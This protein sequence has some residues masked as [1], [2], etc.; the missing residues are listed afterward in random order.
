MPRKRYLSFDPETNAETFMDFFSNLAEN[1]VSVLHTPPG[2]FGIE[3]VK[4]YYEKYNLDVNDFTLS[5]TTEQTILKMLNN[6]NPCKAAGLD[7]L[8]GKFLKEGANVLATPLVKICNL[9]I[10][11]SKFPNKCK[12]AK[13]KPLF[14]KRL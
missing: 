10:A 12:Q 2:K 8:S 3:S 14:K 13:V 1:L 6:I 7:N 11:T 9:S 5:P 4:V